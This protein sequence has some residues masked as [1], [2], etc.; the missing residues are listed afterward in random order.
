MQ[1]VPRVKVV[2]DPLTITDLSGTWATERTFVSV[3]R[4]RETPFGK[5]NFGWT[6]M[7]SPRFVEIKK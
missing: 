5:V 4:W 2:R 3:D 7:S 1:S 6:W